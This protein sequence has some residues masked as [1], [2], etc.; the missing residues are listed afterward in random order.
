MIGRDL[1]RDAYAA[2]V[3][4]LLCELKRLGVPFDVAWHRAMLAHPAT[5]SWRSG[6]ADSALAFFQG[7]CRDAWD[8]C[9]R[10]LDLQALMVGDSDAGVTRYSGARR[11]RTI[12]A[13]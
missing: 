10:A 13:E 2:R 9:G 12:G 6:G 3:T 1:P 4:D 5:V 7:A 8:D 11:R